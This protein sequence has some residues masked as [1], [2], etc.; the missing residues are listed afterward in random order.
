MLRSLM[1][2]EV[3]L[4]RAAWPAVFA[5]IILS[6]IG[7]Y[8]IDLATAI[9]PPDGLVTMSGRPLKQMIY[10][11][12]GISAAAVIVVPRYRLIRFVAWPLMLIMLALLVFVLIPSVPGWLVSPQNGA[13]SWITVG[14]VNF[15]P[16]EIT[17]I[18]CVIVLA[19]YL[20]FRS[21]HRRFWGLIGPTIIVAVP[22][23]LIVLQ[24]DLG[25]A[26]LFGP[27][28]FAMLIAAGAKLRHLVLIVVAAV[29]LAPAGDPML[30]DHQKDRIRGIAM[31]WRGQGE[32]AHDINFQRYAAERIT[33]AGGIVGLSD[34]KTLTLIFHNKLPEPHTDMI[35]AVVANRF[36]LL[37]GLAVLGLYGIWI[38]SAFAT[39]VVTKDAFGRLIV[40]GCASIFTAQ[41]II[42][43]GM[44]L[45]LVPII[46]ITLP[47]LSFGGSSMVTVWLMTGL[48]L[49][50]AM[51]P[52]RS[53][54]RPSFEYSDDDE[55]TGPDLWFSRA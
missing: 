52:T 46:G 19:K 13:R 31:A 30:R 42:N 47:F 15:Q 22:A 39:A 10:L 8:A 21:N 49:N 54:F 11:L 35:F 18:A 36:G 32:G 38:A 20:R 17:K 23:G 45:G 28:L 14:G 41:V 4:G 34:A 26:A 48:M 51:R 9:S 12:V 25:T 27:A 44:I 29:L 53:P 50:I 1:G 2:K 5:S 3:S 33:G 40:V 7:I 37:G 6:L 24:P 55:P 43:V 16:S